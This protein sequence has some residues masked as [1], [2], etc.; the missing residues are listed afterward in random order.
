M[1]NQPI[2]EAL[3][4]G[5]QPVL[6]PARKPMRRARRVSLFEREIRVRLSPAAIDVLLDNAAILSEGQLESGCY[7][8]STMLTIDLTRASARLSEAC[9]LATARNVE[10]LLAS[11]A[12]MHQRARALAAREAERLASCQLFDMHIDVRVSRS[13]RHFHLDLDVEAVTRGT[14]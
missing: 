3:R 9:D 4:P 6:L 5:R 2:R 13:G 14:P 1:A 12:R 10:V 7:E 8:G 11:D